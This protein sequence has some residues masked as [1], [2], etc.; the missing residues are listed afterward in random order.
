MLIKLGN[1]RRKNI[2][3][4]ILPIITTLETI[5]ELK[6]S[7]QGELD[8][9]YFN[10]FLKYLSNILCG[11][12]WIFRIKYNLRKTDTISSGSKSNKETANRTNRTKSQKSSNNNYRDERGKSAYEL[13]LEETQKTNRRKKI[14]EMQY[15]VGMS[16]L[17]LASIFLYTYIEKLKMYEGDFERL[18]TLN[19]MVR[20]VLTALFNMLLISGNKLY[21]HHILSLI[22]ICIV[23]CLF[24]L[25]SVLL[26]KKLINT[27]T[28][29]TSL[30]IIVPDILFSIFYVFGKKYTLFSYKTIY[31]L[32]FIIGIFCTIIMI[33]FQ[34]I[35][36]KGACEIYQKIYHFIANS[37]AELSICDDVKGFQNL[38]SYL[39]ELNS[40]SF[41]YLIYCIILIILYLIETN[42]TWQIITSFSANHYSAS[43]SLCEFFKPLLV[44]GFKN[45]TLHILYFFAFIIILFAVLVFNEFIILNFFG[46][47]ENTKLEIDERAKKDYMEKEE[48][49]DY[50]FRGSINSTDC[51]IDENGWREQELMKFNGNDNESSDEEK[52]NNDNNGKDGHDSSVETNDD[53]KNST[54]CEDLVLSFN[55]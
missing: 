9:L 50:V 52:K 33:I 44:E 28:Y 35:T 7:N 22:T 17:F 23:V 2:L 46:L 19:I 4:L 14:K 37:I 32:L 53:K 39:V 13:N 25:L 12:L 3:L 26:E 36:I 10:Q 41:I 42:I 51:I 48:K 20:I 31:K 34:F 6:I 1:I 29:L 49:I 8:N 45:P 38:F 11:I 55:N 47:N 5:I 43:F 18:I 16:L 27:N 21:K 54:K 40:K 15:F 24:N 30:V